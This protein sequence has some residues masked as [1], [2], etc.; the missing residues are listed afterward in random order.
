MAD[1]YTEAGKFM[2]K[3]VGKKAV[4]N[5]MTPRKQQTGRGGYDP[6]KTPNLSTVD[7]SDSKG[8]YDWEYDWE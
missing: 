6:F 1:W 5:T 3:E 8:K 4:D 7:L 2:L